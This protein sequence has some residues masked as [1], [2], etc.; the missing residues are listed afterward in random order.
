MSKL[1]QCEAIGFWDAERGYFTV[2]PGI[3]TA[4]VDQDGWIRGD[5][6]SAKASRCEEFAYRDVVDPRFGVPLCRRCFREHVTDWRRQN[7]EA[8]LC[9][10]GLDTLPDISTCRDCT[11]RTACLPD[12]AGSD[13]SSPAVHSMTAVSGSA[14][15]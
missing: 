13:H 15:P 1:P 10:C 7:R 8:G 14:V 3:T 2:W 11:A 6:E 9:A 12:R 5:G 4:D